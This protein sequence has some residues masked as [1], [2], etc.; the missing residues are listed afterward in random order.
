MDEQLRRLGGRV[1]FE[2]QLH[3]IPPGAT[4]WAGS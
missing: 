3:R 1:G 4:L 2:L